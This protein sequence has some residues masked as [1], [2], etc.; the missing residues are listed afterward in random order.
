MTCCRCTWCRRSSSS[1]SL[2]VFAICADLQSLGVRPTARSSQCTTTH[3]TGSSFPALK[4]GPAKYRTLKC[5]A[6]PAFQCPTFSWPAFFSGRSL[7]CLTLS[8]PAFSCLTFSAPSLTYTTFYVVIRK[9]TAGTRF[10]PS[11][12]ALAFSRNYGNADLRN[13]WV[14]LPDMESRSTLCESG[15]S[16]F[17]SSTRL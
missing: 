11:C 1:S 15:L 5:R 17:A 14:C 3:C 7:S 12:E 10:S 4:R 8:R 2:S 6:C 9:K 16:R 13:V